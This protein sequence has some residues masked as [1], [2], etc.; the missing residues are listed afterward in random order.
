MER[1]SLAFAG[2]Y[3]DRILPK[4]AYQTFV[5][6]QQRTF[7]VMDLRRIPLKLLVLTGLHGRNRLFCRAKLRG[8]EHPQMGR[9]VCHRAQSTMERLPPHTDLVV[10]HHSETTVKIE[11]LQ[12]RQSSLNC[13]TDSFLRR[14]VNFQPHHAR[15]VFRRKT[16]HIGKVGIQ[17]YEY[18]TVFNGEA[19]NPLIWGTE[20]PTSTTPQASW[21]ADLSSEACN[22]ERFSARTSF[23][24]QQGRFLRRQDEQHIQ[25]WL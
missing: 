12:K 20:S 21:P 22:T 8:Y 23:T 2:K 14:W 17:S 7:E 13:L 6:C 25:D 5:N 19:P 1:G 24:D 10:V 11:I 3:I 16:D 15:R 18:S 9:W 4:E